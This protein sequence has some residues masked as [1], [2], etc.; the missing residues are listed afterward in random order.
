[1][2]GVVTDLPEFNEATVGLV[3]E[4]MSGGPLFAALHHPDSSAYHFQHMSEKVRVLHDIADGMRFLHAKD[5]IH[6]DVKSLN[7]LLDHHGI[8]SM[9]S[10]NTT[11]LSS[12]GGTVAW[13]APEVLLRSNIRTKCDVYSFGVIVWEVLTNKVPWDGCSLPEIVLSVA[14]DSKRLE[15]PIADED[16]MVLV[17]MLELCL[18]RNPD[19]RPTFV[20]LYNTLQEVMIECKKREHLKP[21]PYE[22]LCC[23]SKEIMSA[24]VVCADGHTYDR[25]NIEKWLHD[26]DT[27]PM[28]GAVL[29]NKYFA[30]NHVLR[31]L[32]EQ[33]QRDNA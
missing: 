31:S 23:I 10:Q 7:V 3:T 16:T 1:M 13:A 28:T 33:F 26:N 19:A 21:V 6:R 14:N 30:P 5:V 15:S 18:Q 17:N 25:E 12:A 8:S 4:Y 24:P 20:T 32:I 29:S 11:H 22:F 9:L 27:S 2:L